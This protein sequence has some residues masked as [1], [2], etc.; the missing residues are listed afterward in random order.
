MRFLSYIKDNVHIAPAGRPFTLASGKTSGYYI[1]LRRALLTDAAA[2]E[3]AARDLLG[4]I[5]PEV[6]LL[7]GVPTAGLLLLGPVL[8]LSKFPCNNGR[9]IQGFYTRKDGK[10]H[11]TARQVEG[12]FNP[13]DIACLLEDTVTTGGSIIEHAAVAK[14]MGINVRYAAALFDREEGAAERLRAQGI[15]LLTCYKGSDVL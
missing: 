2:L 7:G 3:S 8:M 10:T 6:S 11:G 12:H 4:V 15:T 14:K 13:E 1:D 9:T 5:P